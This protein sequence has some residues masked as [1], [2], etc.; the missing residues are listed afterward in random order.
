[1][2][3]QSMAKK[4]P[5]CQEDVSSSATKC[6]Y[7][8]KDFRSWF[9]KHPIAS[10]IIAMIVVP[11]LIGIVAQLGGT[12]NTNSPSNSEENSII[13]PKT[14][15]TEAK[16]VASGSLLDYEYEVIKGE[17]DSRYVASF[18][19]FLPNKDSIILNMY[20]AIATK[21]YGEHKFRSFN[22]RFVKKG[23]MNVIKMTDMV[24]DGDYYFYPIKEDTGE[25][26]TLVLWKE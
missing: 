21:I 15:P 4:C 6:P 3:N 1:M 23:D 18:K 7:C 26:H 16:V 9:K 24:E 2:E 14:A 20:G 10:I 5:S 12:E 17:G 22:Y 13:S 25:I 19:P 8:G 11:Y